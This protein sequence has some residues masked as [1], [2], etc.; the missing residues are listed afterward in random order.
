MATDHE[1]YYD[2]CDNCSFLFRYLEASR[3]KGVCTD[4]EL[5]KLRSQCD[6]LVFGMR[7]MRYIDNEELNNMEATYRSL[8]TEDLL[9]WKYRIEQK[10][11]GDSLNEK[12]MKHE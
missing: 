10:Y 6:A 1:V 11:Y 7:M 5:E 3:V 8:N 4:C 2:R 9:N 12:H